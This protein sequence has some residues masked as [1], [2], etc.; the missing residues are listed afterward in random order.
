MT[1]ASD[2]NIASRPLGRELRIREATLLTFCDP[3]S[4]QSS[5]LYTLTPH[6]WQK[7]LHWLDISGLALYF[8]D[9]ITML[10]L[11]DMFP[12]KVLAR[13]RENLT[14][15]IER[16]QGMVL[17]SIKIQQEFQQIGLSYATIKGFS[18]PPDSVPRPELRQQFDLDFLIAERDAPRA[19]II[20]ERMDY[21]LSDI[22]GKSWEFR[23]KQ[24][25]GLSTKDL[26]RDLP[27][28]TVEL[29]LEPDAPENGSL[30]ARA[31]I[32]SWNGIDMPVLCAVD[33]FLGHG[34][35]AFKD[36]YS[37]FFRASRLLEFRRH[38]LARFDDA[39]FWSALQSVGEVNEK[40]S[41]GLGIVIHL[42]TC[43]MGDFAPTNLT[44]WTADRLPFTV[45]VWIEMYGSRAVFGSFPGSKLFLLLRKEL[46]APSNA[47]GRPVWQFLLP[48]HR[49]STVI[50]R[51]ENE[52]FSMR[53]RRCRMQ[54]QFV[55]SRMR[56]HAV[57]GTRYL[58]ES[59]R[60]RQ[61]MGQLS[62]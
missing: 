23:T 45:R 1:S 17:E 58:W 62:R 39:D 10:K 2:R 29:H 37:E 61:L 32:R 3:V 48:L 20:L 31:E 33:L 53:I 59:Y 40:Y 44:Q 14:D 4:E 52:T 5:K 46:G 35:N 50:E 18:H 38:V 30:L 24:I 27:C 12:Q 57:E 13:L 16:T 26:Y 6:E 9:R 19:Q 41:L 51:S 36:V 15:N 34:M 54:L 60:W 7:L 11:C 25:P 56:F 28:R 55:L 49:P 47:E 42:L 22:I 21:R 43:V 8:L